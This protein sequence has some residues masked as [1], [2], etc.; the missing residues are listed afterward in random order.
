[1]FNNLKNKFFDKPDEQKKLRVILFGPPGAGKGTQAAYLK[2]KFC[3]C[4]LSTGDILRKHINDK[5]H[6][7]L[8]AKEVIE[9]GELVSDD[10]I[11]TLIHDELNNNPDC[12]NGFI[13]DGFPRTTVQATKLDQML[14]EKKLPLERVLE[15]KIDDSILLSRISGRLIHPQ[16]GRSYHKIFNPPK[17]AYLDDITNEKLI[18]REDDNEKSLKKRLE[19]YKSQTE[20]VLNF[21]KDQNLLSSID[22]HQLKSNVFTNILNELKYK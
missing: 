13:L 18:E 21:Y 20:P 17:N 9:K 2:E 22:A 11:I 14:K 19:V 7:G 3:A 16:S 15:F 5:T 6:L 12:K 10:I 4:H 1:M 8:K